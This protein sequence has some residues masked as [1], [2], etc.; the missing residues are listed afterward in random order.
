ME[1][2][3]KLFKNG[4][5]QAVRLPKEF[6]FEGSQVKIRKEGKTVILEPMEKE[7]WPLEFWDL[8]ATDN[9]FEIPNALP[10]KKIDLDK[11]F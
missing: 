4:R 5:S 7:D 10:I 9:E 8:F 1:A 11:G 2:I 3:A 6:R